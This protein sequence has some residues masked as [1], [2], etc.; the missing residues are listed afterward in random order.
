MGEGQKRREEEDKEEEDEEEKKQ[1]EVR[2]KTCSSH[3]KSY[4]NYKKHK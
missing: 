2:E 3:K 4:E 1:N